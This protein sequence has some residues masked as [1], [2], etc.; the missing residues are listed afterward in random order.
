M[1]KGLLESRV[2]ETV[3]WA[4]AGM[5]VAFSKSGQSRQRQPGRIRSTLVQLWKVS[6][7]MLK[8]V[9][10]SKPLVCDFHPVPSTLSKR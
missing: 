6:G 1:V 4:S 9:V 5:D 10:V 8:L 3:T 2:V 7:P